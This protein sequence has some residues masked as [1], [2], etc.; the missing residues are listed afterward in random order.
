MNSEARSNISET[1]ADFAKPALAA[2]PEGATLA[3]KRL[4]FALAIRVWNEC[5]AEARGFRE[6]VLDAMLADM[7]KIPEQGR[8]PFEAMT[9]ALYD[10]K[11]AHF[12]GDD[13]LVGA[14]KLEERRNNLMFRC[15]AVDLVPDDEGSA[16]AT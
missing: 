10:R 7:A 3:T 1:I 6:N 12:R 4:M 9:R 14:W 5:A 13:R 8:A 15:E 2:I 11:R 16:G